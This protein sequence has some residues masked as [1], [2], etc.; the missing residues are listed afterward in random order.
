MKIGALPYLGLAQHSLAPSDITFAVATH[1]HSDHV[2]NLNLFTSATHV[3]GQTVS[4]GDTFYLEHFKEKG[5]LSR[6]IAELAKC[7]EVVGCYRNIS[8]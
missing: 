8:F 5:G 4:R 3:V 2:G 1:C 6:E 7:R